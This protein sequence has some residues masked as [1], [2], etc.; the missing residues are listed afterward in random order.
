MTTP[1]EH[2]AEV[3]AAQPRCFWLDG[4][5]ARDWSGRRSI[6]GWLDPDDVSLTLDARA[7]EVRRHSGGGSVV[8]GSDIFEVLEAELASGSAQDQWFGYLGYASRPDLPARAARSAAE[9]G[10]PDAVWMRPRHVRSFTH[11]AAVG[12]RR[13]GPAEGSPTVP[14]EYA[15]AFA[16]VQ[17]ELRAGN[18]YEV[19]L[20]HRVTTRSDLDPVTAYLRLRELN[21][22]PTPG[23][24]STTSTGPGAGCS[25]PRR[26]ASPWSAPTGSARPGRSRAPP[27]A[28]PAQ[29]R[30]RRPA[31]TWRPTRSS[32]PRT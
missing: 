10:L 3:A 14:A 23:S 20:T 4:G 15:A 30:T 8:V 11:A 1:E 13:T 22:A 28:V 16:A 19:N 18:S 21:P 27:R 29:P 7:G 2:F 25:A 24:S 9:G 26:S 6:I 32:V 12:T 5:G 31:R 17:E